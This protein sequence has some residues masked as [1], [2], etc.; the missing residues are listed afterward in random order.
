M[1]CI[2]S[3]NL[4]PIDNETVRAEMDHLVPP[5]KQP[6]LGHLHRSAKTN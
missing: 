6:V 3:I 1:D 5:Q 2:I 4:R